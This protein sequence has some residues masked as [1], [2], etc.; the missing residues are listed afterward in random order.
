[1]VAGAPPG[2][3]RSRNLG[4]VGISLGSQGWG[5][6]LKYEDCRH[7]SAVALLVGSYLVRGVTGGQS[8]VD[9]YNYSHQEEVEQSEAGS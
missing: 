8:V 1:M 3:P 7:S 4:K 5:A 6:S 9:N 2:V